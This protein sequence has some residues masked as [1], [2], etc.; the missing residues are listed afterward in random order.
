MELSPGSFSHGK[1]VHYR[2][3]EEA[4]G[5]LLVQ[6]TWK[7]WRNVFC[8]F[9]S[10]GTVVWLFYERSEVWLLFIRFVCID[11]YSPTSQIIQDSLE[12]RGHACLTDH[13]RI[14]Q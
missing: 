9:H 11:E 6:Q 2:P 4:G 12:N 14:P 10:F 7:A 8:H 1:L 5:F 13:F 3:Q